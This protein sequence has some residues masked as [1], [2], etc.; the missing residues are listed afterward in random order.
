MNRSA[1][2]PPDLVGILN[3]NKASGWT[4]HDVVARV[5]RLAGQKR[6]GHAGT[7]DPMAQGVLPV[8]LGRAT[9]LADCVQQGRKTYE[10][11]ITLGIATDTDDAEGQTVA[12]QPVPRLEPADIL[13]AFEQFRGEILQTPPAYSAL[14]VNGQRAYAV[15]RRGGDVQ[16]AARPVSIE[17]LQLLAFDENRL[18]LRV[19]CSRGTYVRAL[20]R[21][22]ARALGTVGHMSRLVRTRV[23]PFG[24]E[25]AV[26]L[27]ALA[28]AGLSSA[29]LTPDRALPDAPTITV[30]A[31]AIARLAMGQTVTAPADLA[32]DAVWVYDPDGHVVCLGRAG[33]GVLHVGITL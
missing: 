5:R 13:H 16:L 17:D 15:A 19:T 25:D 4:S 7:L 3:V 22:L 8:L 28:D 23:G 1:N 31:A 27:P 14:K 2:I 26:T 12:E 18:T 9:R 30:D 32:S 10:A 6:V 11:D 33:G 21:D 24:L 29:L 20:A